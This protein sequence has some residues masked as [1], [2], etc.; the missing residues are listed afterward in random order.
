MFSNCHTSEEI[1]REY[2]RLVNLHHPDRGGDATVFMQVNKD[3]NKRKRELEAP[4]EI[5]PTIKLPKDV[6]DKINKV[7]EQMIDKLLDS[8]KSTMTNK[9]SNFLK[10]I[11]KP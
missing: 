9:L 7:G 1:K 5:P 11:S 3:M 4:K 8:L 10:N 6:S 2:R